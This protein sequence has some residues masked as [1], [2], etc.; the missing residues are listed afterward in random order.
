MSDRITQTDSYYEGIAANNTYDGI[1]VQALD[2]R[3]LWCN[4]AYCT[5]VGLSFEEIVGKSPLTFALPLDEQMTEKDISAFHFDP[6]EPLYTGLHHRLN[7]RSDG[8]EFWNEMSV[9]F[10]IAP[11]G[12]RHAVTVC[13]DVTVQKNRE[14]ELLETRERL[15]FL[16]SHDILTGI[17]NQRAFVAA[18]NAALSRA[19]TSAER[20]GILR[21]DLDRFKE[22]NDVHGHAAGDAVLVRVGQILQANIRSEDVAARLGGDE[23]AVLCPRISNVQDLDTIAR[24]LCNALAKPFVWGN[25]TLACSASIGAALSQPGQQDHEQLLQQ[26]DFAL[27]D[28]KRNGRSN[29]A[30]FDGDLHKRHADHQ[31][32]LVD[33]AEAVMSDRLDF[34]FQPVLSTLNGT[35]AGLETLARWNHPSRGPIETGRFLGFAAELG[36]LPELDK[37]AVRAAIAI[38]DRLICAGHLD[39]RVGFNASMAALMDDSYVTY[40]LDAIKVRGLPPEQFVAEVLETVILEHRSG[41]PLANIE[42]LASAGVEVLLDDFG[43]GYAGLG[44]LA[45]LPLRGVKIDQSLVADVQS[46]PKSSLVVS[47]LITLCRQ[48]D[49]NVVVEGVEDLAMARKVTQFGS[50]F[51]QGFWLSRP[52]TADNILHLLQTHR[53]EEMLFQLQG[54]YPTTDTLRNHA[55]RSV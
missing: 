35:I 53:P 50:R 19:A 26:S 12:V 3:I 52:M 18:I 6:T 14:Q 51:I 30:I 11:D 27:Y 40:L 23:F 47:T 17:A 16:V 55:V 10:Q 34:V 15:E 33:F 42:R 28:V 9:R 43:N 36:L 22:I 31:R 24:T 20:V 41:S 38:M 49:L 32:L 13:R 29:S 4:P 44:Q 8:T 48:L 1:L 37:A 7:K 46:D 21:I 25:R 2:G 39:I 45:R 5:L 54:D